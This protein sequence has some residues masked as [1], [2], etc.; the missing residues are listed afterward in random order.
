[1]APEDESV[2][3]LYKQLLHAWNERDAR[4][5]AALFAA[6][7]NVTGFDG[8][9]MDGPAVIES[10][11][12]GIF[13]HHQTAPFVWKVREVRSLAPGVALLRAVAGM[14]KDGEIN[15]AVNAVQTLVVRQVEGQWLIELFQ[16]TPAQ[17]H[18]RAE[19]AEALTKELQDL[20]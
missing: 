2:A 3:G 12:A 19:L 6:N 1:M 14:T 4:A 9:Q 16:N 10:M 11:L 20:L 8:S 15:P 13:A 5:Y 18:G 7:A 17:F